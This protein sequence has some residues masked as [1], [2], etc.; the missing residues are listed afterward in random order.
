MSPQVLCEALKIYDEKKLSVAICELLMPILPSESELTG[1]KGFEDPS[2]LAD[3]D[4][5]IFA[6][7]DIPGFDLR[8][9][10]VVFKANYKKNI[11][12]LEDKINRLTKTLD[13][14]KNDSRVLEWLKIV[15]A[16]GNYLNGTSNR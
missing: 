3:P 8:M 11:D 4:K 15:L 13:F 9:K 5:F 14:F 10:S 2:Q 12:E 7:A 1:V 16:Y 6:L